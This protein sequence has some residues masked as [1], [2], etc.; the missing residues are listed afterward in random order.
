[1]DHFFH[2]VK[3]DLNPETTE[4]DGQ[5]DQMYLMGIGLI[6]IED[7]IEHKDQ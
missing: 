4:M 6:L 3:L 7:G 1:V 5:L 2:H